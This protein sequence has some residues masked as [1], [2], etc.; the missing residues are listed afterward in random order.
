LNWRTSSS[1]LFGDAIAIGL[2]IFSALSYGR[3]GR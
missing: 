1:L 3:F 2:A